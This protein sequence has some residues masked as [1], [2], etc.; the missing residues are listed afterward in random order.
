MNL[1][2]GAV[3]ARTVVLTFGD[4]ATDCGV[5]FVTVFIHHN[6]K[7]SFKGI[8]SMGNFQKIIDIC[9]IF[10]YNSIEKNG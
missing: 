2:Q 8:S 9:K 6:K 3:V 4:A 1:S 10:L 7:S 5:D